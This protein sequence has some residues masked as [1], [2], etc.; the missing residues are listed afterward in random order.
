[1]LKVFAL[2]GRMIEV[3]FPERRDKRLLANIWRLPRELKISLLCSEGFDLGRCIK[4]MYFTNDKSV[5][6]RTQK[7]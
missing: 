6:I 2:K 3:Y 4:H 1:M 5:N 7:M